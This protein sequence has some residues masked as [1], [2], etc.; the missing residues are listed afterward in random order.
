MLISQGPKNEPVYTNSCDV[1]SIF[2]CHGSYHISLGLAIMACKRGTI[3]NSNELA[4]ILEFIVVR[5]LCPS[6]PLKIPLKL[7]SIQVSSHMPSLTPFT[8]TW[9]LFR[10]QDLN[11]V[12]FLWSITSLPGLLRAPIIPHTLHFFLITKHS[13]Y[14]MELD[15]QASHLQKQKRVE[16]GDSNS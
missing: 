8:G 13:N 5:V 11:F 7:P 3:P 9:H 15:G 14:T 10:C 1:T 4:K 6:L 16:C 2:A 12:V